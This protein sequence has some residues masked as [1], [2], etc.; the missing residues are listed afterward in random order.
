MD[1]KRGFSLSGGRAGPLKGGTRGSIRTRIGVAL[2]AVGFVL[3]IVASSATSKHTDAVLPP[4][5]T[6]TETPQEV[7]TP[8]NPILPAPLTELP[9]PTT[10]VPAPVT[11][12][13]ASPKVTPVAAAAP[14]PPPGP[15]T[16]SDVSVTTSTDAPSYASGTSV[17]VTTVINFAR[18]CV[19]TPTN[20]SSKSCPTDIAVYD[21]SGDPVTPAPGSVKC[22]GI[23]GGTFNPGSYQSV[24]Y[25]WNGRAADGSAATPGTTGRSGP[26]TGRAAP[27]RPRPEA[28]SRSP[29]LG[30]C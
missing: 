14:G 15:C 12:A 17:T 25:T 9:A 5:S 21:P 22:A 11:A 27:P 10:T 20:A 29:D 19:Y 2:I 3:S 26:G 16:G 6:T 24:S 7:A 23:E 8:P 28:P 30:G 1:S 13:A 4:V 18:S